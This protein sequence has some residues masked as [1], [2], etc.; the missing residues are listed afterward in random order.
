[1]GFIN[2]PP[3]PVRGSLKILFL[4]SYIVNFTSNNSGINLKTVKDKEVENG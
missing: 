3:D 4:E 2:Y 1:M